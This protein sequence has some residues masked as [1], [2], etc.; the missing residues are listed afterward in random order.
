MAGLRRLMSLYE[1]RDV[2]IGGPSLKCPAGTPAYTSRRRYADTC[3]RPERKVSPVPPKSP[4]QPG[5]R[6][7]LLFD[8]DDTLW[9]RC[10]RRR[11]QRTAR[12]G[13]RCAA[14]GKFVEG[15]SQS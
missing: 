3:G 6:Q 8:G 9:E 4:P 14:F 15:N 2:A 5:I 11:A 7:T 10:V 12:F 13:P 1:R